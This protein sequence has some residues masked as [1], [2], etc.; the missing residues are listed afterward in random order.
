[1]PTILNAFPSG[2]C[3]LVASSCNLPILIYALSCGRCVDGTK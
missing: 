3:L 2:E 1:M